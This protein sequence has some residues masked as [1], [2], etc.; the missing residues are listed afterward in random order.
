MHILSFTTEL[1]YISANIFGRSVKK[2][3]SNMIQHNISGAAG[4]LN[5]DISRAD[6]LLKHI[7][8]L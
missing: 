3:S 4:V 8:E 2:H 6:K 5:V 1:V 7:A